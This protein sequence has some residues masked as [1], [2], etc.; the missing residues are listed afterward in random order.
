MQDRE[1][2]FTKMA[3][4]GAFPAFARMLGSPPEGFDLDLDEV[5]EFG[6]RL[7]LDGFAGIV[8]RG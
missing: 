1:P 3:S 7:L 8:E 4:T 5:F 2:E 6:L